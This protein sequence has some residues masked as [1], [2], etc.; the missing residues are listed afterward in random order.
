M[1]VIGNMIQ[2]N[3]FQTFSKNTIPEKVQEI[4]DTLKNKNPEYRYYFFNESD[5]HDFVVTNFCR[6]IQTAYESLQINA[7]KADFWRYLILYKLGGVYID[8]D[9]YIETS[10]RAFLGE[11]DTAL[12][13]RE[14]NK[15]LFVQWCLFFAKE[16]PILQQLIDHC[17]KNILNTKAHKI[18]IHSPSELSRITGPKAYSTII[19]KN[20]S[21]DKTEITVYETSDENLNKKTNIKDRSD[22]ANFF[23]YD[24]NNFCTFKHQYADL[25]DKVPW[26]QALLTTPLVK[27]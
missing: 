1:G 18:A 27:W 19:E 8:I 15:G 14:Q 24:Y 16:H 11:K 7:A 3:I 22:A 10:I 9:S 6:D 2:K 26:T 13:T 20:Y 12:I 17:T 23:G 4:I 5:R 21:S 25:L